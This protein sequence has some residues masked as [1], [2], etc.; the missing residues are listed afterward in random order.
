MFSFTRSKEYFEKVTAS[1]RTPISNGAKIAPLRIFVFFTTIIIFVVTSS[2]RY[3]GK[4]PGSSVEILI[5]LFYFLSIV[6]ATY[7]TGNYIS[8]L[9]LSLHYKRWSLRDR[10]KIRILAGTSTIIFI[11][12]TVGYY[13]LKDLAKEEMDWH[14]VITVVYFLTTIP[15]LLLGVVAAKNSPEKFLSN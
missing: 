14:V 8:V 9:W 3:N 7:C 1:E 4:I 13:T 2:L 12:T 11:L 10:Q 15:P 6:V 5:E